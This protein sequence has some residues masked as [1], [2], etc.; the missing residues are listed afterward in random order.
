MAG[1][2]WCSLRPGLSDRE[3]AHQL[4]DADLFVL[5]TRTRR[6]RSASGEGFGLAL[7]EA[8]VAGTPVVG[9]AYAGSRDAYVDRVTGVA[10]DESSDALATAL[11][12][13][14]RDPFLLPDGQTRR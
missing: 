11:D 1:R 4:A 7:L 12:Q 13:L 8:Q 10:H 6:G 9:P 14:L 2:K 3:L 5:A